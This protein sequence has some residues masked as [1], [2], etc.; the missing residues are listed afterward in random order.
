MDMDLPEDS[1]FDTFLH[2]DGGVEDNF[3][4]DTSATLDEST[5]GAE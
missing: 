3:N 1:D 2:E 4:F 5:I